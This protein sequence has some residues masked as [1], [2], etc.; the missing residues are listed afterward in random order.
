MNEYK[1]EKITSDRLVLEPLI[2]SHLD[3]LAPAFDPNI[4]QWYSNSRDTRDKL[5]ASYNKY[6]QHQED[7]SS[8]TF[9]VRLKESGKIIGSS[10]Y[11]EFTPVHKRLEIGTTWYVKQWQRTFV[12]TEKKLLL[13]SR[14]FEELSCNCVQIKTDNLNLGSKKAIERLGAKFDGIL[15]GHRLCHDGRIRDTAYYSILAEEW[16][17]VKLNLIKKLK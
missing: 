6:L 17:D 8:F 5:I 4:W 15:R 14:A 3:E 16:P 13:L 9:M 1:H 2:L 12:N 7:R 11:L 10:T